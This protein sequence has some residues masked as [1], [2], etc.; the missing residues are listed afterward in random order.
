MSAA[1]LFVWGVEDAIG[2]K[3]PVAD[4][5][6]HLVDGI[7]GIGGIIAAPLGIAAGIAG[8]AVGGT[9]ELAKDFGSGVSDVINA[10]SQENQE[11]LR[12]ER[13]WIN[14][15]SEEREK[16]FNQ[17]NAYIASMIKLSESDVLLEKIENNTE[18]TE[19]MNSLVGKRET[20]ISQ[21]RDLRDKAIRSRDID[22]INACAIAAEKISDGLVGEIQEEIVFFAKLGIE[23]TSYGSLHEDA[24]R[25]ALATRNDTADVQLRLNK[26]DETVTL[27]I[28]RGDYVVFEDCL[29]SFLCEEGLNDRQL[30][31]ILAIKQDLQKIFSADNISLDI[32]KKRMATLFNTYTKREQGIAAELQ[33]MKEYYDTYLKYTYDIP[34]ERLELYEFESVD[35]IVEATNEAKNKIEK[36]LQKQYVQMQIDRVMNKHGMKVVDSAV[37]GRKADDQRILYGINDK[38]AVD[39][40]ISEQGTLSTRVV[41][42]GFGDKPTAQE[43]EQLVQTEHKFCSKMVE[44]EKDLE[45]VGILLR[46]KKSLAPGDVDNNWVQLDMSTPVQR[47]K[48][49]RRRRRQTDNKVM[50]ME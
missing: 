39:V 48:V 30:R 4:A 21:L 41:G 44:I 27:A 35:Q 10:M 18:A 31:D 25:M 2:L 47:N 12:L 13:E 24:I 38:A 3:L 15:I 9:V 5:I 1:E 22:A 40:F 36:R 17:I 33:E 50:Y 19:K 20:R 32:K 16:A 7:V 45:D 37:M 14:Q 11:R 46:K 26:E 8:T 23:L 6:A 28:V 42:V 43:E 34:D 49:N 29:S